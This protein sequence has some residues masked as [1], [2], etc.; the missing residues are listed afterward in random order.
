MSAAALLAMAAMFG[1]WLGSTVQPAGMNRWATLSIALIGGGI[2]LALGLFFRARALATEKTRL[3]S[4]EQFEELYERTPL[5]ILQQDFTAVAE[6]LEKH[7]IASPADLAHLFSKQ[8][9]LAQECQRLVKLRGANRSALDYYQCDSVSALGVLL[10]ERQPPEALGLFQHEASAI[11]E[12]RDEFT[13]EWSFQ[14]HDRLGHQRVYWSVPRRADGKRDLRSVLLVLLD[15]TEVKRAESAL[16]DSELRYR[17]LFEDNPSPM[18]VFDAQS[19]RFLAVNAAAIRQYGY[20]AQEFLEMDVLSIRSV[21]DAPQL[22][23]AIDKLALG[24]TVSGLWRH[25]RK[26]GATLLVQVENHAH[27]FAGRRAV[28]GLMRDVTDQQG[29]EKRLRASEARY[30]LLFENAVEG[31]YEVDLHGTLLSANPAMARILGYSDYSEFLERLK[32]TA[33][34]NYTKPARRDELLSLLGETDAVT[35]FESEVLCVDG[36]LRWIS[37]SVRALRDEHGRITRLQGFV[38]DITERR[39]AE[40]ANRDSQERL[41]LVL[42]HTPAAI[43]Q[44]DYREIGQWL[45]ELRALGVTD[46]DAHLTANPQV[47]AQKISAIPVLGA[48]Q[49]TV[50]LSNARDK[51]HLLENFRYVAEPNKGQVRRLSL[52]AIWEGRYEFEGEIALRT[53]DNQPRNMHYRWWV[54]LQDGKPRLEWTQMALIDLTDIRNAQAELAAERERLRVTLRAMAEA[55]ITTDTNGVVEFM[56]EAAERITG[57]SVSSATGLGVEQV[58]NLRHETTKAN[59]TMPVALAISEHRVVEFPQQTTL[60][61]RSGQQM[62]IDGRCAPMHDLDGRAIGAVMVFRDVTER[63]RLESELMRSSKLESVGIL[64]GGIA[65]DFNNILTVVMGNVTLA[66][67]D[68][69][70]M[71]HAGRWLGEAEKGI[72]RARDLTQQ[73]LTFAKGGQPVRQL[74]QLPDVVREATEFALH[75]SPVRYEFHSDSA[76]WTADVDPGQIGQIVQN[77]VINSVQAMPDGGVIRIILRNDF[78]AHETTKPLAPGHYVGLAITDHGQGIAPANVA[79]IFDPY[80][81]TKKS[82]SGLGLSTVYS[83]VRRHKGHIEVESELGS[84]TTFRIWLPAVPDAKPSL[85]QKPEKISG[86]TGRVLFMDDEETIRDVARLLLKHIGFEPIVV[87]DGAQAIRAFTEARAS[88]QGFNLVIMDLTVPGGMGGREAMQELLKLD[89]HVRAIVSSGYSSDP[90]LSNHRAHGFRGMVSKP[91]KISDL[92]REIRAVLEEKT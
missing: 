33:F 52:L 9:Q 44:Y 34:I 18:W 72:L 64:A 2:F 14:Q 31:V 47:A 63:A 36:L 74:V 39:L 29:A 1:W 68:S 30:R 49:E 84:G 80:F 3:R 17:R 25:R 53:F 69:Q 89:P 24:E 85:P 58:C 83:V 5:P 38:A 87:S 66:M 67:L 92:S 16:R 62:L 23:A 32:N 27:E 4:L 71:T 11:L 90:V 28:L 86:F 50:R 40:L 7:K 48:N 59:V 43:L 54:P 19:L 13:H 76:L 42:E 60:H 6:W 82:G 22:L 81:T 77:L 70:V 78:I 88:G 75:G 45:R 10:G 41:R 35:G 26:D 51:T 65:H 21:Q 46:L 57:W 15:I 61:N 20:T 8:P 73:L 79:R 56:N 37:E 12:G 91:Y 55:L